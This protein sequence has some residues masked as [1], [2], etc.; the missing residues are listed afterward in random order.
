M[1]DKRTCPDC[2]EVIKGRAD[3]KFCSDSCRNNYNN[4]LNS[5]TTN[6]VR[7]INNILR[8]N[9]RIIE[10]LTPNDKAKMHKSKLLEKGFDFSYYTNIY[11]TQKGVM[12]YF[13]YEYGYLPLENDF[14]FLV[15]RNEKK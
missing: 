1:T 14:Y 7:K 9:R 5:D 3:K 10:E 13:C 6:Y 4:K 8:R 2:G 15:K 11:K 12:Y